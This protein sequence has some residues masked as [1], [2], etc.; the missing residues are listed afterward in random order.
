MLMAA[1]MQ[2]VKGESC[3][4]IVK[5]FRDWCWQVQAEFADLEM[6]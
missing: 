2:C 1:T 5:G 6:A 4:T 3:K